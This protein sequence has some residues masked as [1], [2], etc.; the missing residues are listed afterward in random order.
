M[1]VDNVSLGNYVGYS[2]KVKVSLSCNG[3]TREVLLTNSGTKTLWNT[4]AKAL[5]GYNISNEVPK[6]F[7]MVDSNGT[8]LL[9]NKILFRGTVWGEEVDNS[10]ESTSVRLTATVTS[11]D[12]LLSTLSGGRQ[13]NLRMYSASGKNHMAQISDTQDGVLRELYNTINVGTNAIFE[14]TLT[15]S[16]KSSEVY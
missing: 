7:D 3:S 2:G 8:S 10:T 16:N 12:K 14:W 11:T 6:Y 13:C 5:A 4:I 15:F 9:I 1:K